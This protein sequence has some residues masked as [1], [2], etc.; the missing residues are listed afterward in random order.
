MDTEFDFIQPEFLNIL[1]FQQKN[2]VV[3][4][5]VDLKNLRSLELFAVGYSVV[6]LESTALNNL[7]EIIEFEANNSYS[8]NRSFFFIY[9][10][11]YQ[12]IEDLMRIKGIRAV[13]NTNKN[14]ESL[15]N[16]SSFVFYNKKNKNFIN[17]N[18]KYTDLA[19]E[20]F[21]ISTSEDKEI[22]NNKILKIKSTATMIF[23]E[24]NKNPNLTQLPEI[25]KE[26]DPSFWPKII[27]FT[28]LYYNI[29]IPKIDYNAYKSNIKIK[30]I[31]YQKS[32]LIDFSD[33]FE[34]II[35]VNNSI[36]KEF[37]ELLNIYR[38]QHINPSNL[39]L[40]QLY[41]PQKLYNYLRN[42]H[43]SN[44][45]P[46]DFLS[47]WIQMRNIKHNLSDNDVS[48]FEAIFD[49]LGLSFDFLKEAGNRDIEQNYKLK[50]N[51][52][53]NKSCIPPLKNFSE[54]KKFLLQRLERIRKLISMD[55]EL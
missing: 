34:F 1:L 26:Y 22:L 47:E 42:H 4:P 50:Y 29:S 18:P 16:N 43:W 44:G 35:G 13:L 10:L 5:Y 6:N 20:E 17:Y 15:A 55:N 2:L 27:R 52:N 48:D 19:F 53:L 24:V 25:L 46:N 21:L 12:K 41:N 54:F 14:V 40:E 31:N 30:A 33:E 23:T 51:G 49:R 39:E 3:F 11:E 32:L 8:Q 28:E 45:I 37:I 9:N 38:Y 36:A 7:K